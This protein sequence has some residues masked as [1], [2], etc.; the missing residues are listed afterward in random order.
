MRFAA[1][2]RKELRE[3]LPLMLLA[4]I[5]FLGFGGFFIR[6][7]AYGERLF[8]HSVHLPEGSGPERLLAEHLTRRVR[9]HR[10]PPGALG[11]LSVL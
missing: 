7:Q 6:V 5:V 2:L 10:A 9:H 3:C 11:H 4:A 1:L 8:W